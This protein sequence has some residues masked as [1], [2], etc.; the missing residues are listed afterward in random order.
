MPLGEIVLIVAT[1][2]AGCASHDLHGG[3]SG[4]STKPAGWRHAEGLAEMFRHVT[5]VVEARRHG[6]VGQ[7]QPQA[8]VQA[9]PIEAAQGQVAMGLVP[10]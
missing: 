1:L 9:D 5:L 10:K 7:S 4:Q 2:R 3:R 8:H 6:R